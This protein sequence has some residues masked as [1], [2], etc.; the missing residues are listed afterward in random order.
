MQSASSV[1]AMQTTFVYEQNQQLLVFPT[2]IYLGDANLL[3]IAQ[4]KFGN[5][6]LTFSQVI[7]A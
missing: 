1:N 2:S 4:T 6:L 3:S 5:K 7:L